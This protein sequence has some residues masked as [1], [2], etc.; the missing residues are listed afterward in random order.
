[1]RGVGIGFLLV[2]AISLPAV[3]QQPAP[4]SLQDAAVMLAAVSRDDSMLTGGLGSGRWTGRGTVV[5]EPLASLTP[6][7][8]WVSVP[9][10]P[11]HPATCTKFE[12]DYLSKPHTY[13]VIS[14]DGRGAS[15][16]AAP[17]RLSECSDFTGTGTYTGASIANSAIAASS[18][19][20][21]VES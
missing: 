16:Q 4:T 8:E 21:F 12:R 13:T 17:V 7:G 6:S 9:C 15:V 5:V 18:T 2:L 10:D 19:D 20:L 1:M 3:N 11:N 14:A